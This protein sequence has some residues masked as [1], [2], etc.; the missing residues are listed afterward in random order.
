MSATDD[1]QLIAQLRLTAPHSE[2][3]YMLLRAVNAIEDA[4]ARV[5]LAHADALN[6]AA[7]EASNLLDLEDGAAP[8]ESWE[9]FRKYPLAWLYNR[10]KA[11]EVGEI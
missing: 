2:D 9:F 6:A 7:D 8:G 5:A 3:G 11:I 4:N 1:A 10:A